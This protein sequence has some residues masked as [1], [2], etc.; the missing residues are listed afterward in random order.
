M[1][2]EQ[3]ELN[4]LIERGYQFT[5][6]VFVRKRFKVVK[7][8]RT[9]I[10][11]EPTLAVLDVISEVSLKLDI[12]EKSLNDNPIYEARRLATKN[13]ALMAR[14]IALAVVGEDYFVSVGRKIQYNESEVKKLTKIFYTTLKPSDLRKLCEV[15][16]SIA[17]L[18][19]FL[20]SM[21]LTSGARTTRVV[22]ED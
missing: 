2:K 17:N 3:Q 13:A 5:I 15:I 9:Y 20:N 22:I 18:G 8:Q 11:K 6:P 4:L 14:V 12:N 1:D 21:R 19:D 7:E 10:I 16:T